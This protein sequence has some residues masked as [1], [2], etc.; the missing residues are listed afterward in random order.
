MRELRTSYNSDSQEFPWP[1]GW[2]TKINVMGVINL[3]PDSFS[4]GGLFLETS[5]AV[6]RS[7]SM[8]EEGA[9]VLDLGAQSTRPGAQIID[10]ETELSRLL[11]ALKVI[12]SSHS[13]ALI[14]VDTFR[15]DVAK[16]AL[17]NGANWINDVSGGNGDPEMLTLVAL[18]KCPYVIMHSRGNSQ[19]MNNLCTYKNVVDDVKAGLL[20]RTEKAL[21]NGILKEN[22]I[23]DPGLGFA[24]TTDQNIEILKGLEQLNTEGFPLL[25]G[26]S[27][28]RFV[29]SIL[30]QP[31]P[32]KRAYGTSA[33]IC[34]CTQAKVAMVRVHDVKATCETILMS[35]TLWG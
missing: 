3:T 33:V 34:R 4:D 7:F 27:R 6:K 2:R 15:A 19:T 5:K 13:N 35:Q 32:L 23:W 20:R 10:S 21:S 1:L 18:A 28:K 26:P 12:R 9:D 17:E 14:S 16:K 30:N 24:K 8:L 25:I 22:I 29:G 31:D 11:P